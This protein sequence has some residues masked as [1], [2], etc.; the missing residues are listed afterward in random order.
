MLATG[1]AMGGYVKTS[2]P[3]GRGMAAKLLV[4]LVRGQA[5]DSKSDN[6]IEKVPYFFIMA[7]TIEIPPVISRWCHEKRS[8]GEFHVIMIFQFLSK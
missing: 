3:A 4:A 5:E 1:E 6:I 2:R 7:Q 8:F